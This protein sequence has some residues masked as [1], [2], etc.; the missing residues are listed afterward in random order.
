M[1]ALAGVGTAWAQG[2]PGGGG[3]GYPGGGRQGGMGGAPQGPSEESSAPAPEK[4]DK[5]AKKAYEAGLKSLKKARDYDE[6]AAKAP[7]EDKKSAAMEKANDAYG[8]ALDQFT[9]AL[10]NK[11]D[12]VEAWNNAAFIHLRFGAYSEAID[13]Y[14]HTLKLQ[15]QLNDAIEHRAEAYMGV[16]R[17]Q[18]AQATYMELFNHDRALADQLLAVMQKWLQ[19]HRSA[20]SGMRA[21]D[22]DAFDKWLQE[23]SGI[24]KQTASTQ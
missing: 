23:R 21:S 3:Q 14:N 13:D 6:A 4:P 22:I 5:A 12:M 18:D 11:G 17:L 10:I 24:A 7:N 19:I 2:Y 1:I 20:A 9:E 8:R 15:P 16:D